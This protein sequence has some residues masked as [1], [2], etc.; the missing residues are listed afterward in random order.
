MISWAELPY[1]ESTLG[2]AYRT[3]HFITMESGC[4]VNWALSHRLQG[5]V[6]PSQSDCRLRFNYIPVL[7]SCSAFVFPDDSRGER[8][9]YFGI[10]RRSRSYSAS[11]II[12]S[13][14]VY[15]TF[16][17][18]MNGSIA[19]STGSYNSILRVKHYSCF[20]DQPR[21]CHKFFG[22]RTFVHKYH[23]DVARD[24]RLSS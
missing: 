12:A 24:Y 21:C 7:I 9:Q 16:F 20:R 8:L 11:I 17:C 2:D 23:Q 5:G 4:P 6:V 18:T 15:C 3:G 14:P 13:P 10:T 22:F 19:F 1:G